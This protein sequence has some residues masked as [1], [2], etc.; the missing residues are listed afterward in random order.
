VK[1]HI[2]APVIA[3]S[4]ASILLTFALTA[5]HGGSGYSAG[6]H[7]LTA[8]QSAQAKNDAKALAKCLPQSPA[9]QIS[10]A[11]SLTTKAG[12]V[13]L[14]GKCGIAPQDKARFEAQVLSAAET[15]HLSNKADRYTFFA[16]TLPRIIEENQ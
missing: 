13:A 5:C 4:L 16:V 11:H 10:L 7:S 6:Q 14:E 9:T 12:R 2:V 3:G 1:S 15:G 8:S